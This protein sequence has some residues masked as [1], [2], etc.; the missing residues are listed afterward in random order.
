[1]NRTL[2]LSAEDP[3]VV[4]GAG[5]IGAGIASALAAGGRN[6][7]VTSGWH[8]HVDRI[9]S[10]GMEI[11]AGDGTVNTFAMRACTPANLRD[12]VG[13]IKVAYITA[14][15]DGVVESA[16]L[17]RPLLAEDGVVVLTQN[18]VV[19]D[20]VLGVLPAER[21]LAGVVFLAASREG[22]G[23]AK[24]NIGPGSNLILGEMDGAATDRLDQ[25]VGLTTTPPWESSATTN[26]LG[27]L[28]SKLVVN[29]ATNSLGVLG[30][31]SIGQMAGDA[32]ARA[33]FGDL[34]AETVG[35]GDALGIEFEHLEMFDVPVAA[36]AV[37]QGDVDEVGRMLE[38]GMAA[39]FATARPS[40]LQDFEAGAK[41]ELEWLT[42]Y[43]IRKGL[44]VGAP[45]PVSE[46]I[47]RA[48]RHIE[49]GGIRTRELMDEALSPWRA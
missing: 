4:V 30:G 24:V 19:T 35:V 45:T 49:A 32:R 15:A 16:E 28:W 5:G 2:S 12:E 10:S 23:R 43:V 34:V 40:S 25:V 14:K 3:I 37:R 26:L 1:M 44:E 22:P 39:R 41:S 29:S 13:A 46:R 18:G 42:G 31:W 33:T 48:T 27:V 20:A 8:E 36:H 47:L 6:V 21:V 17:L 9:N 11:V 38:S 7:V